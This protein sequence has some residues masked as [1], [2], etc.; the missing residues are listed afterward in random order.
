MTNYWKQMKID[1]SDATKN[2]L[3]KRKEAYEKAHDIR[4]F[5][6]GLR[7]TL[8]QAESLLESAGY[9][10]DEKNPVDSIFK[11]HIS[12]LDFDIMKI[13]NEI[14]EK[15]GKAFFC[16]FQSQKYK[17]G[18]NLSLP[19]A[20]PEKHLFSDEAPLEFLPRQH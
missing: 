16:R 12:H 7:L 19:Q 5:E 13:N 2:E 18:A 11:N 20:F 8:A 9:L 17:P 15:T 4:K 3:K 1:A 14:F 6:I 10:F